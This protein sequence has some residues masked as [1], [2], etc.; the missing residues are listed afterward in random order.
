MP[1]VVRQRKIAAG[2]HE[3]WST[4]SAMQ[5]MLEWYPSARKVEKLEG[6]DEGV[7]RVQRVRFKVGT[8]NATL[9]QEVTAWEPD[10]RIEL[11][12]LRE[13]LGTKQAPLL[14]RDIRTVIEIEPR[15]E[16]DRVDADCCLVRV[17]AT[18]EPVGLKGRLATETVIAPRAASLAD[19]M[20][21]S[22]TAS[23]EHD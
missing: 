20:I 4:I 1:E 3:I 9:D 6:P 21:A 14:A 5:A 8:R 2:A 18:W 11:R 15:D 17:R 12:Q 19:T 16:S 10:R 22:V 23:C 7:G 13:F